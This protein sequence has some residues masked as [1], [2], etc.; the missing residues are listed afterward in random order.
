M[1]NQEIYNIGKGTSEVTIIHKNGLNAK[2]PTPISINGNIDSVFNWLSKRVEPNADENTAP[3]LVVQA[4]SYI[5]I[6][7]DKLNISLTV[8]ELDPYYKGKVSGELVEHPDFVKWKI[9]SGDDWDHETLAEFVK[10]NRSCFDK[11]EVAMK[12]STGLKNLTVNV[13]KELEK[14]NDNRGSYKAML[15]QKVTKMSIPEQFNLSVP[16]FKGQKQIEFEVEIYVNPNNYRISLVSPEAN[17]AVSE[18][19]DHIIDE[20]ISNIIKIA[21]DIVIIE[22]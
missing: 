16:I 4:E 13:N 17:D 3:N 10:M 1:E 14:E 7:R 22:Q 15:V 6:N 18:V 11:K 20:Q 9:N 21:P 2:A 8:H 12:L 5:V 19:R